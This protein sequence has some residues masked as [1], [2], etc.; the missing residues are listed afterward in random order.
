[1]A[2][3]VTFYSCHWLSLGTF[4]SYLPIS[5][6]RVR[7]WKFSCIF[8]VKISVNLCCLTIKNFH[9][10]IGQN[11]SLHF[12]Q[13]SSQGPFTFAS[14]L[15][16]TGL[17]KYYIWAPSV[18]NF[19]SLNAFFLSIF[20]IFLVRLIMWEVLALILGWLSFVLI[21]IKVTEKLGRTMRVWDD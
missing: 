4:D 18:S 6:T 14:S 5:N 10:K 16:C 19:S 20:V 11:L 13:N 2:V 12:W 15:F 17:W 3:F 8:H 1:M 21:V 7:K 9:D